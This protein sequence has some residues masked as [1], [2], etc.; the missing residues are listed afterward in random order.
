MF[1]LMALLLLGVKRLNNNRGE[2]KKY[3]SSNNTDLN[4]EVIHMSNQV[5]LQITD[6]V[7][8]SNNDVLNND[9]T[10]RYSSLFSEYLPTDLN[11]YED[12]SSSIIKEANHI[13]YLNEHNHFL[14][15]KDKIF[16]IENNYYTSFELNNNYFKVW[17]KSVTTDSHQK[18]VLSS[19]TNADNDIC[20]ECIILSIILDDLN[21]SST[22]T[23]LKNKKI[24]AEIQ[25]QE[26]ENYFYNIYGKC[27][28]NTD[29]AKNY[30]DINFN[31]FI[32]PD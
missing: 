10:I 20:A 6:H 32:S 15:L 21:F 4:Y 29:V 13:A 11:L 17:E 23:D 1:G 12:L 25:K 24:D 9:E 19:L 22:L 5:Y 16:L 14:Y 3:T 28:L 26:K 2:T 31:D 8:R 7:K 30:D 18:N 27:K